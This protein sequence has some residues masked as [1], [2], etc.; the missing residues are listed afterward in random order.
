[1]MSAIKPFHEDAIQ[2]NAQYKYDD[3]A[4]LGEPESQRKAGKGKIKLVEP[5]C[6]Q[7]TATQ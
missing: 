6:K 3:A 2:Q 7:Y 4:L 5:V 1:M